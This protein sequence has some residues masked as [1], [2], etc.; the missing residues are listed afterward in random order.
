MGCAQLLTFRS[1]CFFT[2]SLIIDTEAI[3]WSDEVL[4][5]G[6]RSDE[7][8]ITTLRLL[9]ILYDHFTLVVLWLCKAALLFAFWRHR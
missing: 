1:K 8:N 4:D 3:V 9:A 6:E 7:D 2:A 5:D